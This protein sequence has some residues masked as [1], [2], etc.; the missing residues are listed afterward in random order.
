MTMIIGQHLLIEC[1]GQHAL[2]NSDA[3][4]ALMT[5]AAN[6]SGAT[7]LFHHFHEFGGH[8]GITGVLV[9]AESHITG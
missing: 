7:I 2:L 1:R 3:L 5:K 4:Q 6:A 9:L 8:G